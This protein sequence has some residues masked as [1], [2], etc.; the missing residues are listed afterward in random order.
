MEKYLLPCAY[1]YFFSID[2]P[3]CGFQRAFIF[4]LKGEIKES[5]LIYPPF[6]PVLLLIFIFAIHLFNKQ[7]VNRKKMIYCSSIVLSIITLNYFIK[8]L[9]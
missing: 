3:M 5:F 8:L 6:L 1:K 9:I 4:M 7:L 2:C